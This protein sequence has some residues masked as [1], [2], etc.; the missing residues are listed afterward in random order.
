MTS[1]S[2]KDRGYVTEWALVPLVFVF[3]VYAI[4]KDMV[5][6]VRCV[7]RHGGYG[8]AN[9][10]GYKWTASQKKEKQWPRQRLDPEDR[11]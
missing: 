6:S 9:L 10:L 7:I 11:T 5:G 2:H 3:L 4:L 8:I 1:H